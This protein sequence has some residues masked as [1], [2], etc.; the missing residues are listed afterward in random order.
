M[1]SLRKGE[2]ESKPRFRES[3]FFHSLDKW[4]FITREGTVEG[5]FE[6]RAE[7]ERMLET[8]LKG[9]GATVH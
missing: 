5:P 1:T 7:A 4:Y 6:H 9:M 2:S 8:Y 3:R